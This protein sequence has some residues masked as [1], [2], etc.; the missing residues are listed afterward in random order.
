VVVVEGTEDDPRVVDLAPIAFVGDTAHLVGGDDSGGVHWNSTVL[1]HAFYLSVEGGRNQTSGI[2]VVGVG[3]VNREQIE[4]VYFRAMTQLMP[5]VPNLSMAAA[6]VRQA[7]A[8]L[9]SGNTTVTR[10]V[11]D[12][13]TA[14]GLP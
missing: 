1:S 2:T 6:A 12:G 13:L 14:V 3:A 5:R 7:A 4:R 10:A 8:D 11:S 9:F